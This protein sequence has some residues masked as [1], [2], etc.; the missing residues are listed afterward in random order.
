[1]F[2]GSSILLS[3]IFMFRAG[4]K[5]PPSDSFLLRCQVF[6][7]VVTFAFFFGIPLFI[8]FQELVTVNKNYRSLLVFCFSLAFVCF[9]TDLRCCVC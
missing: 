4:L 3:V 2:L 5:H 6:Y 9:W 8:K 7:T 1:M